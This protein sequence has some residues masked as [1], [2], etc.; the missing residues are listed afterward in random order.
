MAQ[1]QQPHLGDFTSRKPQGSCLVPGSLLLLGPYGSAPLGHRSP[2]PGTNWYSRGAVFSP[3][4]TTTG[5]WAL[6]RCRRHRCPERSLSKA[7]L[8]QLCQDRPSRGSVGSPHI[9]AAVGWGA[10]RGPLLSWPL[11]VV[12][13][14]WFPGTLLFLAPMLLRLCPDSLQISN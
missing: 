8:Q 7:G 11:F 12:T 3:D 14:L 10:A 6:S 4:K 1:K 2:L 9:L 5:R 13:H